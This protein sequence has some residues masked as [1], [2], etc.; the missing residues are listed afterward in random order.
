MKT[1][2]ITGAS[3]GIGA[4]TARLFAKNGYATIINY[5]KSEKEAL[6][7]KQ[8]LLEQGCCVELFRA[9]VSN[10]N[11]CKAM[12][13]YVAKKYK[14]IDVLV[15][16]AGIS[17]IKPL[18]DVSEDDFDLVMSTNFKSV[19]NTCKVVSDYMVSQKYGKIINLSSVWGE[20]GASCESIYCASKAAVVGFTKALAKE[21]GPSNINVNCVAPGFIKTDMNGCLSKEVVDEIVDETPL[22]RVGSPQDVANAILFL[23]EDKSG[24]ITGQVLATSGGWQM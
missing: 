4:Q 6:A 3:R 15:N 14:R 21:L 11:E 2:I 5:N 17:Q 9:D 8:E 12:A 13:D 10:Y 23:A 1:V 18:F 16:N 19:F 20:V 7:L 24:F 22:A